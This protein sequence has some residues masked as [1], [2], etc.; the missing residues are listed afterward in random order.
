MKVVTSQLLIQRNR[1]VLDL[2]KGHAGTSS[3]MGNHW[4]TYR[5]AHQIVSLKPAVVF[6]LMED[7]I[8]IN[9]TQR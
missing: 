9:T 6:K 4:R 2:G 3:A 7:E 8:N 1:H 5:N